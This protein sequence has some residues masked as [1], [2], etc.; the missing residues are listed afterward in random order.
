MKRL[1][2][3]GS[4]LLVL[5]SVARASDIYLAQT[6]QGGD[7]GADCADAK[8]YTYFNSSATGGN[9]YHLCGTFTGASGTTML[10]V[11]ASGTS[12]APLIILFETNAIM[13]SP[14][15]LAGTYLDD[16][17]SGG[18]IAIINKSYVIV[19]GGTNGIIQN[20]DNGTRN[21]A[22]CLNGTG[23]GGKCGTS[24]T[25]FGLYAKGSNI[26]I[27]NL[28][29][30]DIY[31]I[32]GN[33][34]ATPTTDTADIHIDD[35]TTNISI[36]NNTL[37]NAMQGLISFAT[38][39]GAQNNDC[40]SNTFAAGQNIFLNTTDDHGW[41][42]D[43]NPSAAS[44]PNIYANNFGSGANW[45]N[46]PSADIWHTDGII[47]YSTAN[48]VVATPYIYNNLFYGA[49]GN[50]VAGDGSPT[51]FIFCTYGSGYSNSGTACNIFN[52]VIV[53]TQGN[54]GS[55][56]A[57]MW[58]GGDSG[59]VVGPHNIYNNTFV[60]TRWNITGT[61]SAA[62]SGW[63]TIQNN[64]TSSNQTQN[65]F[66][67]DD[68]ISTYPMLNINYN[69]YYGPNQADWTWHGNSSSFA[70]W[71]TNC[72]GGNGTGCDSASVYGNPNLTASYQLQSGSNGIGEGTNLTSLCTGQLAPLCFDKPPNVGAGGSLS[73]NNARP[74][75]GAWDAGAYQYSSGVV[76][77]AG[78]VATVH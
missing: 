12:S 72:F 15:W 11:P 61:N 47:N 43:M 56:G 30:R 68:G 31:N 8:A 28:T 40:Q 23:T 63:Y 67:F 70:T 18:A 78:L 38:G 9:T 13:Q 17:S 5:M 21:T 55:S 36:C 32:S 44:A 25:S 35:P 49:L 3:L 42:V 77:P 7:T 22:T 76:P 20:T 73:G 69:V 24:N 4:L 1:A 2:L 45:S 6:A 41:Q 37:T 71:K 46:G 51:G 29:I 59:Y 60:N 14:R 75:S 48:G 34:V 65:Q 26:I 54:S 19:D 16:G 74:S 66:L 62:K 57:A 58:L 50:G 33:D 52:N 27:R 39:S 53:D 10:T 64:I